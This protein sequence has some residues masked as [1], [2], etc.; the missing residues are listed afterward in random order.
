ME[1]S[2]E[3]AMEQLEKVVS[4]LE[5]GSVSLEDSLKLYEEGIRLIRVCNDKLD[6]AVQRVEA[7]HLK[8][9]GA[10]LKPFQGGEK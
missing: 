1:L 7:V 4:K 6:L 5:Q 2:F 9:N 3:N 10:E 8:E